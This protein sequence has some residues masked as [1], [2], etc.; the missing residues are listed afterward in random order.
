MEPSEHHLVDVIGFNEVERAMLN[1]VFALAARRSPGFSQHQPGSSMASGAPGVY[2]V[3]ADMPSAFTEFQALYKRAPL[4]ALL[5]GASSH[6]TPHQVFARPL[7]WA[8]LLQALDDVVEEGMGAPAG[9][10]A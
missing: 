10:E 3:D 4:P 9:H 5:V 1:S 8:R 2:L 6:G 7:Q